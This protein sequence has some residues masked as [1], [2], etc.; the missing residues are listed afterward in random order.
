MCDERRESLFQVCPFTSRIN[1]LICRYLSGLN[2]TSVKFV[3]YTQTILNFNSL[4]F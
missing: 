3:A 1:M 4:L 2:Y